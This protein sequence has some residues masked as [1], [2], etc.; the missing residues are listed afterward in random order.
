M[1]VRPQDA[2]ILATV[3]LTNHA[4]WGTLIAVPLVNQ[5]GHQAAGHAYEV[6]GRALKRLSDARTSD[7][8]GNPT[9]DT[10]VDDRMQFGARELVTKE[11][12]MV[13]EDARS[14]WP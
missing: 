13:A 5:W 11:A 3:V 4:K 12:E 2:P 8:D 10:Y 9:G 1:L 14:A 6:I 7:P